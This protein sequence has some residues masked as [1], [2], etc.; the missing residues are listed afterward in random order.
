MTLHA[1]LL[2]ADDEQK[3]FADRTR[4]S[5]QGLAG[6]TSIARPRMKRVRITL[7][8]NLVTSD[9]VQHI[10]QQRGFEIAVVTV[11]EREVENTRLQA[12][13][14][15][16]E[17]VS[18][19]AVWD[20][21][22]WDASAVWGSEASGKTLADIL[23]IITHGGWPRNPNERT[24]G[25]HRQLRDAMILEAHA[26]DGRDIFV[27]NDKKGFIR[28]GR[29]AELES[30]LETRIMTEQEFLNVYGPR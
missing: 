24:E 15:P 21:S 19:T 28:A 29:R 22:R 18:E 2:S 12:H 1:K 23:D 17:K 30:L 26:R 25:H 14:T 27:T 4:A 10:A 5:V 9:R 13:V 6:D 3:A 20:E 16:L 11:T 8:T 7:D